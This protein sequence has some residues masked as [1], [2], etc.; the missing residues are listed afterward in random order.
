MHLWLLAQ[1]TETGSKPGAEVRDVERMA[2]AS[3]MLVYFLGSMVVIA[4]VAWM[5]LSIVKSRYVALARA[6]KARKR[7]VVKDA[8]AEAG[9]RLTVES[10]PEVPPDADDQGPDSRWRP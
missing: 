6:G 10:G 9:R 2:A 8:W 3:E 4:L 1:T 7:P 5:V